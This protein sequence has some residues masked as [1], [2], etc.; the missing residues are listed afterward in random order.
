MEDDRLRL[1]C[2]EGFLFSNL[3]LIKLF[4]TLDDETELSSST[5]RKV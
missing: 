5:H 2:P 4:E 1:T 3:V